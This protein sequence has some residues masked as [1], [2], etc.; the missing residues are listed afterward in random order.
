M[1]IQATNEKELTE[2]IN[3]GSSEIEIEGD[4]ANKVIR[5]KATGKVAWAVAIGAIIVAIGIVVLTIFN[6]KANIPLIAF[7]EPNS[8]QIFDTNLAI[9]MIAITIIVSIISLGIA[10]FNKLRF[11]NIEKT[12][13]TSIKLIKK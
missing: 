8:T 11:Y 10:L 4:L 6:S 3:N 9:S 5:I 2:A 13:L 7:I 12:S 1:A